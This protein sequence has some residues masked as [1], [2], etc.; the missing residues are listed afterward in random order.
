MIWSSLHFT[1]QIPFFSTWPVGH[2]QDESFQTL[3]PVQ[4]TQYPWNKLAS[5]VEQ[6]T[7]SPFELN[8]NPLLQTHLPFSIF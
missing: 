5:I 4:I 3:P 6:S 2:L 7:Q 8:P 1:L